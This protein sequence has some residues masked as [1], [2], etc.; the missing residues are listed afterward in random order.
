MTLFLTA[1]SLFVAGAVV[2]LLPGPSRRVRTLVWTGMIV[3][4]C[5]VGIVP[6]VQVL[7]GQ[8]LARLALPW[9]LPAGEIQ[10]SID[11]LSAL[12]LLL[13]F[14][15]S[16]AAA[17]YAISYF[18][19]YEETRSLRS[20]HFFLSTLILFIALLLAAGNGILFLL[21][22]ELIA[23]SAFFL[24]IFEHEKKQVRKA[25]FL[26]L[27]ATHTGTL[28]LFGV[29]LLLGG[30]AGSFSFERM[31]ANPA[32]FPLS[33]EIFLLSLV[34]FGI[35]AGFMPLHIW[36]QEAHPAAPSP[37]SALMSGVVI[38]TG[39][40][41]LVRVISFFP[42]PP[43]WW[44]VVLVMIGTTS[45]IL[46]V[47]WAMAQHDFKRLLAYHSIENIGIIS[48]GLGVGCL[49]LSFQN[50]LIALLGFAGGLWHVLNHG[51]FKSLLFLGAGSVFHATGSR[52]IDHMGG[53][54]KKMPWTGLCILVGSMAICGLPPLN[55]F[56]SEWLIYQGSFHLGLASGSFYP[57]L[58][59]PALALIGALAAACFTKAFGIQFL[60][61]PRTAQ[62][63]EARE[64]DVFM[65]A[66][67]L[68][69]SAICLGM[70][71]FPGAVFPAIGRAAGVLSG[72][73]ASATNQIL[74]NQ[75]Q[76]LFMIGSLSLGL[77]GTVGGLALLRRWLMKKKTVSASSTWGCG[78]ALT[79][80]R[81]QYSSSS[82]AQ[83]PMTLFRAV[84]HPIVHDRKA[85]GYFP[86]E[87]HFESQTPDAVLDRFF[88][89]IYV[90]CHEW[91]VR[92]RRIQQG[93][94]PAYLAYVL[95]FLVA[96]L[97]WQF[98]GI[99]LLWRNVFLLDRWEGA[100]HP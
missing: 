13:H 66:P 19:P 88:P 65:V 70:G 16:G 72:P 89:W 51:L 4:G 45:G 67:M 87:G 77:L 100:P 90:Q 34:A 23:L 69:L 35:K 86:V 31:A 83:F 44:G 43:A 98:N 57:F 54:L 80:P 6:A 75:M 15:V 40:Y 39:I 48:L 55:G 92:I 17:L 74:K 79:G 36:L 52:E 22:W 2:A 63:A 21:A 97:V 56:V 96:L 7:L 24:I 99:E 38:K 91:M 32:I 5:A 9:G 29:F 53:L 12:F 25:G 10:I 85:H 78:Y 27:V 49:G 50:P 84:L 47:L 41:G 82:F 64:S 42:N 73:L 93:W 94:I 76:L 61:S 1:L 30:A 59:I 26:Y 8:Q 71:L 81:L 33:V 14:L 3:L 20:V 18:R 95:I 60:G 58:G 11:P 62:A 46:G 68:F 28:C 37:V